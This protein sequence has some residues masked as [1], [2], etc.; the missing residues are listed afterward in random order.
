MG[1]GYKCGGSGGAN[2]LN[3][4]VKAYPSEVELNTDTPKVN[5]VGVVT[6]NPITSWYFASEQ[7][8]NMAE[9]EVWFLSGTFSTSKFNAL[10]RNNITVYPSGAKQMVSG[11]LKDVVAKCYQDGKWIDWIVYLFKD[12]KVNE[13]LTGGNNKFLNDCSG[14]V[15]I[16]S[17][18]IYFTCTKKDS[19]WGGS[20]IFSTVKKIDIS[21]NS[22][23]RV[24]GTLS[25][26]SGGFSAGVSTIA[27][28]KSGADRVAYT[29]ATPGNFDITVNIEAVNGEHYIFLSLWF[30]AENS[31]PASLSATVTKVWLE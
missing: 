25:S 24:Q 28:P 13:T 27:N 1:H 12:G 3:F 5:T 20:T 7:P 11:A 29:E 15:V 16:N 19:S 30:Y 14:D 22:K 10:K 26:G 18:G 31:T 23:L 2:P 6:T 9:G 4:T 17:D 8:E 21:A